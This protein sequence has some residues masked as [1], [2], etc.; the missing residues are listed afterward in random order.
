MSAASARKPTALDNGSLRDRVNKVSIS[1]SRPDAI[2][3]EPE[4]GAGG[5]RSAQYSAMGKSYA[6]PNHGV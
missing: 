1:V 2:E 4:D 6:N 5:P 3:V